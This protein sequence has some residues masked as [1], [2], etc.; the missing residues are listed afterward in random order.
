VAY[1][2]LSSLGF[3]DFSAHHSFGVTLALAFFYSALIKEDDL[4]ASCDILLDLV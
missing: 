2:V 1:D 4:S 3:T